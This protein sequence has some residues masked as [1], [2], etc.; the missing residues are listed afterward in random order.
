MAMASAASAPSNFHPTA[1]PHVLL[2]D[3]NL[4]N[5]IVAEAELMALGLDVTTASSA[6]AA[7]DWLSDNRP[8]LILMDCEMP[9]MDGI[10]ATR[11]IR[12]REAAT[13]RPC[14]PII[15]LTANG[16]DTYDSRCRS[17]GMNDYLGKPFERSE[18]RAVVMR[19]MSLQ[20]AGLAR[21]PQPA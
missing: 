2:V 5:T 9:V 16:R 10:A 11:E 19:H 3:D 8:D 6:L 21:A 1:R 7:L 12:V 4:V 17:A 20:E 18:L 15:A 13:G 14:V